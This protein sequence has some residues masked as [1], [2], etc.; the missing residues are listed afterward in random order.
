M[1]FLSAKKIGKKHGLSYQKVDAIL[2]AEELI[3]KTTKRPSA[4][5]MENG[6]AKIHTTKSQFTLK[7][8]E[9]VVWDYSKIKVLF[10]EPNKK[11]EKSRPCTN[12]HIFVD[13]LDEICEVFSAFGEILKI[14]DRT[15]KKGLSQE[16][17]EA[18]LESCFS[19]PHFLGGTTF[20]HKPMYKA[21]AELI[22]GIVL[23][24]ANE[25][26]KAAEMVSA[27]KAK[28][29]MLELDAVLLRLY[30]KAL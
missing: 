25:L 2:T 18:V 13:P 30:K 17:V 23:P 22:K 3:N 21:D 26:F 15:P 5:S 19:D 29:N 10:P 20:L 1:S 11:L 14:E 8:V 12:Q 16:V 7:M 6:L 27:A 4:S 28:A 9:F 24:L